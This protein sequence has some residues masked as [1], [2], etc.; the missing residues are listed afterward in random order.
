M[1]EGIY[2]LGINQRLWLNKLLRNHF[3]WLDSIT[4]SKHRDGT[5]IRIH[6]ILNNDSYRE[7]DKDWLNKIR[8]MYIDSFVYKVNH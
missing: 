8:E 5:I 2:Y 6:N 4:P 7:Y 3:D 1:K